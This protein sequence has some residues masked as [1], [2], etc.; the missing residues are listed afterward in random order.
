V[1]NGEECSKFETQEY[2][3]PSILLRK[4]DEAA[5]RTGLKMKSIQEYKKLLTS[6]LI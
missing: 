4:F 6:K 2:F 5:K 3:K 1:L